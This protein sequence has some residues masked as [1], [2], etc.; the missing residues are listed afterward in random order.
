MPELPSTL[1]NLIGHGGGQVR[2]LAKFRVFV[3]C[4]M[5]S[6]VVTV[7]GS[8]GVTCCVT[9]LWQRARCITVSNHG[10]ER[11]MRYWPIVPS[12]CNICS[13]I[14]R[15]GCPDYMKS[16]HENTSHH[17]WYIAQALETL[18]AV[19]TTHKNIF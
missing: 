5:L 12:L 15:G 17:A 11:G 1:R 4:W 13:S 3:V 10:R 14:S 7:G 18:G 6:H 9:D 2:M 8:A 19:G 16:A